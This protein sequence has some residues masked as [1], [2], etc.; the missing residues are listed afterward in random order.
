M[1]SIG[2]M[3]RV[4]L[5]NW[6]QNNWPEFRFD[7]ARLARLEGDFLHQSGIF[8]GS[9]LH[10]AD[11]GRDLLA[12]ELLSEEALKTSEI[13]GEILN[14]DSVQSSIRRQFGLATDHRKIP[15]A[16]Q[17]VAQ[18]MVELHREFDAPMNEVRLLH[19]HGLLMNGRRDLASIGSYRTGS[20]PMQVVSGPL[21][22]PKVHF[23]APASS[24]VA[25]EMRRFFDWYN[26]TAPQG[27]SPLPILTR[28]GI[29]HL[30]FVSIHPFEDGN[31]RIG[32]ALVEKAIAEGLGHSVLSSLSATIHRERKAYYEMLERSNKHNEITEWLVFFAET[33]LSAQAESQSWVEFLIEKTRMLDRV[34]GHLNERQEKAILRMTREGPRGFKGGLSAENYLSLTSTSRATA[35][36]DLQDLVEKGALVRSGNL[37]GTRYY[38]ACA[39]ERRESAAKVRNRNK[40]P[41]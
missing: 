4:K 14:R 6:Q 36:R 11:E 41:K 33:I 31:G 5:W 34:R 19:W 27:E 39:V 12:L 30:Y 38:L 1:R 23:E 40:V 9:F 35:T 24:E 37:K 17:G 28:A 20:E 16:E 13:E 32:R 15:P 29:C 2:I 3:S 10:I 8:S 18:L 21:H 7:A 25:D 22:N 26:R